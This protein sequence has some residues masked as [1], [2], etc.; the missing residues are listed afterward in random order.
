MCLVSFWSLWSVCSCLWRSQE[1]LGYADLA[2]VDMLFS[3]SVPV[4]AS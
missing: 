1:F 3:V 2:I 4:K